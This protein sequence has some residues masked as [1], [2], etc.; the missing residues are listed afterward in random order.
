MRLSAMGLIAL[1]LATIVA[2]AEDRTWTDTSGKMQVVG[3]LLDFNA[4]KIWL[5][6]EDRSVIAARLDEISRGDRDYI[7]RL[8]Q[9]R[10]AAIDKADKRPG[11]VHYGPPRELAA[12]ANAVIDESSGVACSH[13]SRGVFFTHNDSDGEARVFA[14][15]MAG[16]D[17]GSSVLKSI[18][19]YD[20]EDMA[21]FEL[22]GK[23]Y[24]LLG[25]VGNNGRAAAVHMLYLVE[26]PKIDPG[27]G[28]VDEEIP[29]LQVMHFSYE[30]DHR[31]CEAIA[32]DPTSRTILLATKERTPQCHVYAMTW[33]GNDPKQAT[34]ARK[35]VTLEMPPVTA[36]DVS[37]DGRRAILL[38]YGHA[39]EFTRAV[40]E[41]WGTAFSRPGRILAMPERSQGES[42]CYGPDG[43]TLYLTSEK[44]P[45]PLWEVPTKTAAQ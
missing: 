25:D 13:T 32:V 35:I 2:S 20:W 17:L 30:D 11:H 10:A 22:D 39:Y 29:V 16:K 15:D 43:K 1:L 24:L 40:D 6:L 5:R 37:P 19:A 9:K 44:L 21:S 38:T 45:T 4:S 7:D 41:D 27:R 12:L 28:V 33:P 23:A 14:F 42:I 18:R 36:M 26:E 3:E 34:T 8:A 31:N